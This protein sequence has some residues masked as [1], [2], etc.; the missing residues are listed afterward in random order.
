MSD[1]QKLIL[2]T[3]LLRTSKWKG[4]N[5]VYQRG[6]K[7]YG[8]ISPDFVPPRVESIDEHCLR[9]N[10]EGM[11]ISGNIVAQEK[12]AYIV[13]DCGQLLLFDEEEMLYGVSSDIVGKYIFGAEAIYAYLSLLT[14]DAH[15]IFHDALKKFDLIYEWEIRRIYTLLHRKGAYGQLFREWDAV[16]SSEMEN[17]SNPSPDSHFVTLAECVL[18][19]KPGAKLGDCGDLSMS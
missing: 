17:F 6:G 12:H 4:K 13:M 5:I 15:D 11:I 8:W 19:S 2:N 14:D 10:G 3:V 18:T 9:N 16:S 7:C 1:E